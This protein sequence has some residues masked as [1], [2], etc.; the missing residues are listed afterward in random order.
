MLR[1]DGYH[2]YDEIPKGFIG[3]VKN[4]IKLS[5]VNYGLIEDNQKHL[6]MVSI[7]SK[8][9]LKLQDKKVSIS[10][11]IMDNGVPKISIKPIGKDLQ[12]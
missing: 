2:V 9:F 4:K 3:N 7:T 6:A 8:E 12:I 11:R 1:K 10:Y 5:G